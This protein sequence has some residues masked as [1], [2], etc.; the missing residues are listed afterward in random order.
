VLR[1][2]FAEIVRAVE[3][4]A[5][6]D[7]AALGDWE[8][9]WF[10]QGATASF[11]GLTVSGKLDR[12]DRQRGTGALRVVDYKRRFRDHWQTA[13]ATQARRAGKLQAPLYLEIA[14]AVAARHGV[15]GAVATTAVF[16]FVEDYLRGDVEHAVATFASLIRDGWFFIR[17]ADGQGG[18]CSHCDFAAV[19]RKNYGRLRRKPEADR[20]PALAG[21][22]EI[23]TP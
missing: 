10:E 21:Y 20:T 14:P 7:L 8:P 11:G 4:F 1:A 12:I 23:V 15:A 16:Q 19:C 13:L 9:I 17:V 18:H 6:F 3:A 2:R 22:W 5:A